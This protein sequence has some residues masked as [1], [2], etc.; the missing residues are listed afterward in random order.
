MPLHLT[1]NI[2]N[3]G[4]FSIWKLSESEEDL[5]KLRPLSAEEYDCFSSLKNSKRR[6]EWLTNRILL[7]HSTHKNFSL[8][9]LPNGKP[10][11]KNP[12]LFLSISHSENFVVVCLSEKKNTGVDIEKIR[13]NIGLL[14]NKFLLPEESQTIDNSN[15]ELLHVYWGAKEA[16]YKMYSEHNPLFTEHL[17]LSCVDFKK[18]KAVGRI[19][20]E[21]FTRTVSVNFQQIEDNMLVCCFED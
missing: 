8:E 11:L 17:S 10:L 5:L 6:R 7:E 4:F 21:N 13:E 9:H 14:K 2:E 20:K 18:G 16:M 3:T 1:K 12:D 15:I 19:K